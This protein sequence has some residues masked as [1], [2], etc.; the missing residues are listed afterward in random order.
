MSHVFLRLAT[1]IVTVVGI[2]KISE[3]HARGEVIGF[4][5][6]ATVVVIA[7]SLMNRR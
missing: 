3:C 7:A 6:I 4:V 2:I 1:K 5:F